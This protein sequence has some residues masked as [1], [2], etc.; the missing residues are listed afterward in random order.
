M[1]IGIYG[2]SF[3][4]IHKGHI[5]LAEFAINNLNL[6]KLFFVPANKNPFKKSN[7]YIENN[8]RI[9]MINLVLKDKMFLSE[10]ETNRKGNSYTI[11]TVNYFKKKFPNDEIFLLIGSD[12]IPTLNKWKNIDEI[13]SKVKICSFNRGNKFSKI[14]LKKFNVK[15]LKNPILKHSSTLYKKGNFNLVEKEVQNYIGENFLYF[16]QIAKNIIFDPKDKERQFRFFHL[17]WTAEF[18]TKLAKQNNYKIKFAYQAGMAHDITKLWTN[19]ESYLFLEKYGF[20]KENLPAYKLHQ[21][22][23]Y[24]WLKDIYKYQNQEV[25]NAIKKHTSL[26][27]DLNILDKILYV[28]DKISQGRHWEG[29]EKVRNLSF[30]NLDEAL[31]YIVNRSANFES[32]VRGHVFDQEQ[33]KIYEKWGKK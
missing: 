26:D 2:G 20:N 10:F 6:D 21:T 7:D 9:N 29:I 24:F 32:N 12:N 8:H 18:A 4:P 11:D 1:K 17:K 27:W 33:I 25:L 23:A 30:Q 19:E 15:I 13:A 22:T 3:N 5:E 16:E 14:N 31:A 28:S